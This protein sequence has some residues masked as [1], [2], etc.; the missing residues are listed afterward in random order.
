VSGAS[1]VLEHHGIKFTNDAERLERSIAESGVAYLHAPLFH[2]ALAAVAPLRRALGFKTIFNLLGPLVNPSRPAYQLLGVATLT[3]QRLYAGV[4]GRLNIGYAVVNSID[5]YD[6]VSLTS[7]FKL[8]TPQ[9]EK[10]YSPADLRLETVQ[11]EAL[12]GGATAD[13]AAAIFD[14][15]L[16]GTSTAA[17]RHCVVA[18]AAVAIHAICPE[19]TLIDC[20]AEAET[21]LDSGKAVAAFRRFVALNSSAP[22]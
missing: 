6:E 22:S 12:F 16:E 21:S 9:G 17:Q 3:Q 4:L 1:T 5:G 8:V 19:K 2:P 15:V 11:S 10:L 13:E 20:L 18:N 7:D 14:A